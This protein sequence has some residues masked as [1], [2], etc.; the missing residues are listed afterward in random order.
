LDK[1]GI[2]LKSGKST[3]HITIGGENMPSG[4]V[5][6][7]DRNENL[8]SIPA[9]MGSR[10]SLI[11][12]AF[13][14]LIALFMLIVAG[15]LGPFGVVYWIGLAIFILLITYQHMVVKPS[16]FSRVNLAF[17]T[18]NGVASILF[19]CFVIADLYINW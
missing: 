11:L 5:I 1:L 7:I 2:D 4:A 12:S 16:D 15:L 3:R 14:H 8:K 19:S 13:F 18:L 10:N 6:N 9:T 17:A